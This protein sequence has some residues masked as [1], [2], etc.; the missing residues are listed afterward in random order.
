MRGRRTDGE[1]RRGRREVGEGVDWILTGTNPSGA[2]LEAAIE[3]GDKGGKERKER[4]LV[5]GFNG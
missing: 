2:S 1:E 5:E 4:A 3:G